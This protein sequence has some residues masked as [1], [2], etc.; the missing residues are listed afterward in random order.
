MLAVTIYRQFRPIECAYSIHIIIHHILYVPV[1]FLHVGSNPQNQIKN[2]N[3]VGYLQKITIE[4]FP[5]D[6]ISGEKKSLL[7]LIASNTE[8]I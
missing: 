3:T 1:S 7:F 6:V 8:P 2:G 5:N 4:C